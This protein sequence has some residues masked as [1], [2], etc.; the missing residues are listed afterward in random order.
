LISTRIAIP[1]LAALL[2]GALLLAWQQ[3]HW[4]FVAGTILAAGAPLG[5]VL[6]HRFSTTPLTAHPLSVSIASGFG[7]VAVM[8]AETRFGPD[9]SWALFVALAALA[10]WMLW[11]RE[12]RGLWPAGRD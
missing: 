3:A 11:Q 9:H 2:A 10:V 12:Q 4:A 7:C 8:V 6:W 5:F 1:A